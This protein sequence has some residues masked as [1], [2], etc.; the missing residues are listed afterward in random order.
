MELI[1]K[2]TY[3]AST[4]FNKNVYLIGVNDNNEYIWLEE[5]SWDCN[6]YWG[7]GYLKVY[8]NNKRPHLSK[9]IKTHSHFT[10]FDNNTSLN[11]YFKLSK[12]VLSE[13]D[14]FELKKLMQLALSLGN[15]ARL[16]KSKEYKNIIDI[17]TQIIEM[18]NI[19]EKQ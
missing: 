7:F 14:L 2:K 9:D 3:T 6:W 11:E 16:T 19:L 15:E 12:C 18:L 17:H 13:N 8:T 5:P 1:Q 10:D 4:A